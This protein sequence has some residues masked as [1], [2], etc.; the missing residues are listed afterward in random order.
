MKSQVTYCNS[1]AVAIATEITAS[2]PQPQPI[3][4]IGATAIPYTVQVVFE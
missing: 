2:G 3:G 4:W 1:M